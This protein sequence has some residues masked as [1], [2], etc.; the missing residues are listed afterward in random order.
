VSPEFLI[1][2]ATPDDVGV[3]GWHRARMFQDM[4]LVPDELFES[5]R[6]KALDRLSKALASGD[7]FGW[8]V[9]EPKAPR[10]IIAGAGVIIR[11]V[12]PFPHRRESGGITIAEGRQGLIIN[13]FTEP[14]WRRRGIAKLLMKKI[15]A[16]SREQSLD[17]LVLH[18]SDDG[19]RL[20]EQLGFVL[21]NE[22]RLRGDPAAELIAR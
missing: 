12:P 19:R 21:T 6:T 11:V 1:R 7:Y 18:A 14:E 8:L 16:W 4:G 3:I 22:M 10:K 2:Q 17:D 20:Y 5:F 13:V 9:C 15:I